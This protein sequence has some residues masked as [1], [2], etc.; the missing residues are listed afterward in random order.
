MTDYISDK[1]KAARERKAEE[2]S[3]PIANMT[4]DEIVT[5]LEAN[6]TDIPTR[7]AFIHIGRILLIMAKRLK[8]IE[9]NTHGAQKG[10]H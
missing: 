6:I 3:N 2:Q 10:H 4:P 1:Q 9:E 8:V 5:W 7:T